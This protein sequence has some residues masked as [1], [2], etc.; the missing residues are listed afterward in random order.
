MCVL[1]EMKKYSLLRKEQSTVIEKKKEK[2]RQAFSLMRAFALASAISFQIAVPVV[3]GVWGGRFFDYRLGTEPWLMVAGL[4]LGLAAG[5]TG[6][7]RIVGS[8]FGE[9][10]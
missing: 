10:K 1:V 6:V 2:T 9:G 7:I 4:F 3:M 8:F 5:I